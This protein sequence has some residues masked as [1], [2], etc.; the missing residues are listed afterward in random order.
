VSTS[1][2]STDPPQPASLP[3]HVSRPRPD[4]SS[5]SSYSSVSMDG[6][7]RITVKIADLGNAC[8]TDHHFTDD[9]QTRQYRCPEVIL[10]AKWGASADTWSAASLI[11]EL[12]TGGDYLFDPQSGTKYSKDDDH[13][14][15]MMELVGE[16]PKNFSLSGKWSSE[17]FNRKGELRH[18]HKLRFWPLEAVLHDKY[19]LPKDEADLIASFLSPMLR[20]LP[21]KRA[22][23]SELVHH[24]WFDGIIV[25]G[26]IDQILAA[27]SKDRMAR[28]AAASVSATQRSEMRKRKG[29]GELDD[30]AFK[31]EKDLKL[32]KE[33][34]LR[35]AHDA[36]ALK[37][38]DEVS[39]LAGM[40]APLLQ[41]PRRNSQQLP[42]QHILEEG[43]SSSASPAPK[44]D[45]SPQKRHPHPP[46]PVA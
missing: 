28:E 3:D 16:F 44:N 31:R 26:E 32:Q 25:Q 36:D 20:V 35:A 15:Q 38:V 34:A 37:P 30:Q 40:D 22:N 5:P 27:E 11:F 21:E 23:S 8:W 18:I 4:A 7:E 2:M 1:L 43:A 42:K 24:S 33:A 45:P 9:I 10:G 41:N 39:V 14:A 29:D 13:I 6:F 19:L 12:L 17:F 46:L